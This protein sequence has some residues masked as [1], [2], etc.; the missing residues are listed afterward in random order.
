MEILLLL[1]VSYYLLQI[2]LILTTLANSFVCSLQRIRDII[3][4]PD[5]CIL[6]VHQF[7]D[8]KQLT[9]SSVYPTFCSTP[10]LILGQTMCYEL[11]SLES[12]NRTTLVLSNTRELDRELCT[13]WSTLYT[14]T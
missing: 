13:R 14:N 10:W 11:K 3:L 6:F 12:D 1:N 5:S 9:I 8:G 4:T 7:E 2:L